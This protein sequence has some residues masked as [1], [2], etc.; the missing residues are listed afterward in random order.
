MQLARKAKKKITFYEGDL[1]DSKAEGHDWFSK[2]PGN[3]LEKDYKKISSLYGGKIY[4][5]RNNLIVTSPK[6]DIYFIDNFLNEFSELENFFHKEFVP[7]NRDNYDYNI[8]ISTYKNY[9]ILIEN[10]K[11]FSVYDLLK[12][13]FFNT[14]FNLPENKY[15]TN[16]N[17]SIILLNKGHRLLFSFHL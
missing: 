17:N 1:Y 3:Y 9:L 12:N 4:E 13:N 5:Y 15:L 11:L 10:N 2:F 14:R 8:K 16:I 6:G 7:I